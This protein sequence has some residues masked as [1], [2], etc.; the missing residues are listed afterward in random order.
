MSALPTLGPPS[1]HTPASSNS[2]TFGGMFGHGRINVD[3]G[4]S[5]AGQL[6]Q[7]SGQ[8]EVREAELKRHC[9]LVK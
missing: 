5:W 2:G 4:W 8:G 6:Q 9:N 7:H 1:N 3:D